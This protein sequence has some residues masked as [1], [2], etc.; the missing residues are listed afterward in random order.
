MTALIIRVIIEQNDRT[1]GIHSHSFGYSPKQIVSWQTWQVQENRNVR[2][3]NHSEKQRS[4]VDG[5]EVVNSSVLGSPDGL[6]MLL[7]YPAYS[8]PDWYG[9]DL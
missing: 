4:R 2:W 8:I 6:Y 5:R 9:S 1:Y 7:A 3:F